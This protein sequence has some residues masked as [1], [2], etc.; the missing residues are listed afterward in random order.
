MAR[1]RNVLSTVWLAMAHLRNECTNDRL[2]RKA[3]LVSRN[4]QSMCIFA[5]Y[6]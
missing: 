5:T 2:Q 4:E 1:P 6:S 3:C